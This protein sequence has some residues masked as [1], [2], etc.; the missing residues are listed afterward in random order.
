MSSTLH[1]AF[2]EWQLNLLG[3]FKIVKEHY[4]IIVFMVFSSGN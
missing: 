4:V 2:L 3:D 1:V